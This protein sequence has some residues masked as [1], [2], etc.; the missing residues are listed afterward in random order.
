MSPRIPSSL[1]MQ[2]ASVQSSLVH[3]WAKDAESRLNFDL[4]PWE[5]WGHPI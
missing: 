1:L 2:N 5:A 4:T 3:K